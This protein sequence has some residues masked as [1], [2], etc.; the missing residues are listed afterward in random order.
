LGALLPKEA[1]GF[2]LLS[3]QFLDQ[4]PNMNKPDANHDL[5]GAIENTES[6]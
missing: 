1:V 2:P 3:H 4:E 6:T 5:D